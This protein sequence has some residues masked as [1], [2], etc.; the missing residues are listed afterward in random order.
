MS[1]KEEVLVLFLL[2]VFCLGCISGRTQKCVQVCLAGGLKTKLIN[3]L[4][5]LS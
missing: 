1:R 2:R 4:V 3:I 5:P